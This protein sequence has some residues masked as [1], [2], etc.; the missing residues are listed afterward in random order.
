MFPFTRVLALAAAVYFIASSHPALAE[1]RPTGRHPIPT[2]DQI[3]L[4]LQQMG[5]CHLLRRAI[6]RH[7]CHARLQLDM[8]ID[9]AENY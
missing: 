9:T 1:E 4:N 7:V 8:K 6:S 3:D 5:E 2:G